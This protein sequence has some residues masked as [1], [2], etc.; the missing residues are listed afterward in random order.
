MRKALWWVG[1]SLVVGLVV[2]YLAVFLSQP[3]DEQLILQA[4]DESIARSKEG[5]PGGIAEL[6]WVELTQLDGGATPTDVQNIRLAKPE[7]TVP[8]RGIDMSGATPTITSPFF[9]KISFF[10]TSMDMSANVKIVFS[11]GRSTQLLIFPVKR[12]RVTD[13]QYL[14]ELALE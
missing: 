13:V 4:L 6:Y 10:G 5:R 9:M 3:T 1:G 11:P 14:G 7:V 2:T 8:A 12:W